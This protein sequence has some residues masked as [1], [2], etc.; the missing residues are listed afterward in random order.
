MLSHF[1]RFMYLIWS[2]NTS[3]CTFPH[4][5]VPRV[6]LSLQRYTCDGCDK[7]G[8]IWAY[9]C[10][11]CNFDLHPDCALKEANV[12]DEVANAVKEDEKPNEG[13]VC[14]GGVCHK[15]S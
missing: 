8:K 15:P 9:N 5:G 11:D 1:G 3:Y 14:D 6:V 7:E 2:V 4:I 12:K 13:W 10:E